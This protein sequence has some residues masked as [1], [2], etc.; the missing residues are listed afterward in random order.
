[1]PPLAPKRLRNAAVTRVDSGPRVRLPQIRLS[2]EGNRIRYE[3]R[4]D[5]HRRWLL[6]LSRF[7][8]LA[9]AVLLVF[10]LAAFLTSDPAAV[11]API[12]V[13]GAGAL[14]VLLLAYV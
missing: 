8:V 5:A 6:S 11:S 2:N 13:V 9:L 14:F 3:Q 7:V 4:S 10:L 12:G 1:M